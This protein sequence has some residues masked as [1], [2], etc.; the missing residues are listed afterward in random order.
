ML[1]AK[2]FSKF[3]VPGILLV[4]AAIAMRV[5]LGAQGGNVSY[6]D[7]A[8]SIEERPIGCQNSIDRWKE[9]ILFFDSTL[10]ASGDTLG[11]LKKLIWEYWDIK[12]AGAGDASVARES[13]LPLQVLENK[14]SGCV[15]LSWL[16]LMVAESRNIDLHGVLLPGHVFLRYGSTN[17]EPNRSGYSYTDDEYREK[18]KEG[19]WTGLELKPLSSSQFIGLAVF[20]LGN[21]YLG[22]DPSLAL[23]WYRVAEELFPEYQGIEDNQKVAKSR[24]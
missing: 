10:N 13:I 1:S 17:V 24:L 23:K 11:S 14:K 16:A 19:R 9:G 4:L 20:D 7:M 5:L 22:S 15:G 18:Y 8:C 6:L 3:F 2:G 21:L 12:F